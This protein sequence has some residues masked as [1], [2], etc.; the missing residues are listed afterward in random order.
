MVM[1]T[2]DPWNPNHHHQYDAY[3]NEPIVGERADMIAPWINAT[4]CMDMAEQSETRMTIRE[5][6][7]ERNEGELSGCH[8]G[9][10]IGF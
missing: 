2:Q 10:R 3:K 8:H 4:M 1:A 9:V 6:E 5:Q 7:E